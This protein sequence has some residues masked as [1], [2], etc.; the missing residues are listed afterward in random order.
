MA[1]GRSCFTLTTAMLRARQPW[2]S[3]ALASAGLGLALYCCRRHLHAQQTANNAL[4][5]AAAAAA[6]TPRARQDHEATHAPDAMDPDE[7]AY[8]EGFMREA[9]AM[10]NHPL[11]P[12]PSLLSRASTCGSEQTTP[13]AC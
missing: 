6:V 13:P 12:L 3:I 7:R 8:H 2:P 9:I 4:A 10:V 5:A 11:R 1:H